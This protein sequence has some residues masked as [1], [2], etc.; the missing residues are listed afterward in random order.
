YRNEANRFSPGS[1]A[2]WRCR[3]LRK[4]TVLFYLADGLPLGEYFLGQVPA[5][6][7]ESAETCQAVRKTQVLSQLRARCLSGCVAGISEG[8]YKTAYEERK[9][10]VPEN[11]YF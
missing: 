7:P 3:L 10:R 8:G 11:R 4:R 5:V 9:G 1:I 6:I 2:S